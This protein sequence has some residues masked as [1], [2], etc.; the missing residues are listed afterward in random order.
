MVRAKSPVS[1]FLTMA[2]LGALVG[3]LGR[4]AYSSY[5][6]TRAGESLGSIPPTPLL[7]DVMKIH[8]FALYGVVAGATLGVLFILVDFLRAASGEQ[9]P[10]S[11]SREELNPLAEDKVKAQRM[12]L[13]ER[14]LE[15]AD[16]KD[17]E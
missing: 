3:I 15:E 8:W 17:C 9:N 5:V 4:F 2:L 16:Q 10:A 11:S 13:G 6:I 14:F 7:V 12:A 1:A